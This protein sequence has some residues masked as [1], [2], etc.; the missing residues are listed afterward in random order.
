M[1]ATRTLAPSGGAE[2]S[3]GTP[4]RFRAALA[5]LAVLLL[6]LTANAAGFV[7]SVSPPVAERG[8]TTRV[9]FVGNN[10]GPGLDVWHSLPKGAIRAKPVPSAPGKLVFDLTL[11][12]DAP[13]GVCGLRPATR[14][15]LT[16]AVLFHVEDLPVKGN[17]AGENPVPLGLPACVWGTFRESTC[18]R[19]V[20]SVGAGE[21]VS[22]ECVSNRL[23]KDAD[24]LLVVRDASGTFVFERD[25]DPG[26]YFD[27]RFEHTFEKA[28]AYTLEVRDAR[29]KASAHHHYT[30]R[31]GKFPPARVAVPAAV[32]SSEPLPGAFFQPLKRPHDAGSAWVPVA[33]TSGPV[34]VAKD[35]DALRERALRESTSGPAWLAFRASPLRA[36]PFLTLE[37]SITFGS[38]QAVPAT[39][40]GT[41]CGVLKD[42]GR[43]HVFAVQ[44]E[45]GQRLFARA[46]AKALNSPADLEL[47]VID[48]TG[49]E[50][51]R[52]QDNR[53]G[54]THLDFT[55]PNRGTYGIA[56]RDTL[57]DGSDAHTYRI[58][59][60]PDPFPP[61]LTAEV[62]G[63]TVPQGNYQIVPITVARTG[64]K[65]PIKLSLVGAPPGV[66]LTPQVISDT[67]PALVCRLEAGAAAPLGVHTVQIVGESSGEKFLIRTRPLIDKKYQN[68]DLIPIAL[69]EDQ[70][71]L[72]PA[73]TDRF[74]VQITPPSPFTFELPE[75]EVTL[76][77][78]Q[79]A[80]IPVTTTRSDGFDG[81]I[82]FTAVGGQLADKN[83]GRTRVYAEFPELTAQQLT[84]QGVVV[85]KILSNIGRARIEVSATGT[86]RGRRVTLVRTFDL[87]LSYAYVL[88]SATPKVAL[89]P[90]E[91]AKVRYTLT[92]AK[93]FDGAVTLHLSAVPGLDAP[94]KVTIPKGEAAVEFVVKALPDAQ[95]RKQNWQ[96]TATGEVSGFEEEQR[97]APVEIEIKKVESPKK[98]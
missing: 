18:D 54:D 38:L 62:E 12:A 5:P 20:I 97:A 29:L 4:R 71:R 27:F 11:S 28:G 42:A 81:P 10:F 60:R 45:K 43:R 56:V 25:N 75:T 41:L 82:A 77:R 3:P 85:S 65:G 37:R 70:M 8:K 26:L 22:F 72:P 80:P 91:S 94:E 15:G 87:N 95:P 69:R 64:T 7:E 57:R 47:T 58:T 52:G 33:T 78:Y 36:N 83:E 51:R 2:R 39:V 1:P 93:S 49:R 17:V 6:P 76:P 9:T 55:S 44:L 40:P 79:T 14:D 35:V 34:T 50:Q 92:R 19:Y 46:E 67:E 88:S 61:A 24:P 23:G 53:D 96:L 98:K 32:P 13:V 89:L 48:R 68:V 84:A 63:L 90:G 74:A 59:V 66:R 30:L 31:A 86:H 73:L 16:N 21:T